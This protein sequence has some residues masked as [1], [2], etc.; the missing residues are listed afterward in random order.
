MTTWGF[1]ESSSACATMSAT[2]TAEPSYGQLN[3]DPKIVSALKLENLTLLIPTSLRLPWA[4]DN[5]SSA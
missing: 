3:A 2:R 4:V 1:R 5:T